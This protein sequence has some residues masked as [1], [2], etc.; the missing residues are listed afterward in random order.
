MNVEPSSQ[1]QL[2]LR[3]G[4]GTLVVGMF[5]MGWLGWGLGAA[6]AFTPAVIV[7]FDVFGILLVGFSIYFIR[8]GRSLRRKFPA[9]A[10]APAHRINKQFFA[11]FVLEFTAIAVLGVAA[12]A[13]HRPD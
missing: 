7:L 4:F 13:F 12:Y 10:N 5:G 1:A 8:K 11:I 2:V 3:S 6:R 9:S